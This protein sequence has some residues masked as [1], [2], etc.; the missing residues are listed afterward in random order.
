[1]LEQIILIILKGL[2]APLILEILKNKPDKGEKFLLNSLRIGI[3][4]ISTLLGIFLAGFISVLVEISFKTG[5][6]QFNSSLGIFLIIVSSIFV[7]WTAN[8]LIRN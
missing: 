2:I 4:G 1:M 8:I 3:I 5:E 7:W 6:I